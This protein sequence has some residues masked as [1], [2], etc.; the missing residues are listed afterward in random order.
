MNKIIAIVGM[1]GAGKSEASNFFIKK[2][3]ER[4]YFGSVIVE[5]LQE[6]G[7]IRNAENESIYRKKIRQELGMNAVAIKLLPKIKKAIEE[8]KNIILDGLYSWEEYT[9]LKKEIPSLFLLGIYARPSVRHKRLSERKERAFTEEEA[10]KRDIDEIVN[11][12]KGGPIAAS[13][14]L[15]INQGSKEEFV[16]ELELFLDLLQN[17]RL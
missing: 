11:T 6:E 8:D 2:G 16:K 9:F 3:F 1:P 14:Y 10:E 4:V 17:D 5:G 12:N 15:I 13:D 7:L